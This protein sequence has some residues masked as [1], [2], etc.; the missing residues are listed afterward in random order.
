[1]NHTNSLVMLLTF[2][3]A[4][5]AV[6]DSTPTKTNPIPNAQ[7]I[8]KKID[9]HYNALHSMTA[10]FTQTVRGAGFVHTE[11]GRISLKRDGRMRWDYTAPTLKSFILEGK[12]AWLYL[13][14]DR[15]VRHSIV[16][17]LEDVRSPLRFLLGH[18]RIAKELDLLTLER[19]NDKNHFVLSGVPKHDL[20]GD[21]RYLRIEVTPQMEITQLW[22][23]SSTGEQSEFKFTHLEENVPLQNSIFHFTP[24]QGVEVIEEHIP[25]KNK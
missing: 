18:A 11:H 1:M 3:V 10:D 15:Q 16:N 2:A 25:N 21:V 9:E 12:N 8:A 7:S 19:T 13:P 20:G 6:Q 14:E 22:M 23:E 17:Q 4:F 24:P 5:P